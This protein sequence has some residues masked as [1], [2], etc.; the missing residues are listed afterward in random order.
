MNCTTTAALDCAVGTVIGIITVPTRFLNIP[1]IRTELETA[2]NKVKE[3]FEAEKFD[4]SDEVYEF[5]DEKIEKIAVI[6]GIDIEQEEEKFPGRGT[7]LSDK[8]KDIIETF[9]L[10]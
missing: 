4:H 1:V 5:I 7:F 3:E 6:I 2:F 8:F 9:L 10:K